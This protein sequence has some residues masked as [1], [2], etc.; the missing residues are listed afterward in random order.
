MTA[1]Q[2]S[3]GFESNY[4]LD[5]LKHKLNV[6]VDHSLTG[7]LNMTWNVRYQY[8]EGGYFNSATGSEVAF[9]GYTLVDMRLY[10]ETK[11]AYWFIEVANL[12][13]QQYEDI[14]F[15]QQPGRWLRAGVKYNIGFKKKG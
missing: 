13:N 3:D 11:V 14:G 5:Y 15:V 6:G 7:R 12:F 9:G 8:R 4:V 1:D 2:T 10:Q